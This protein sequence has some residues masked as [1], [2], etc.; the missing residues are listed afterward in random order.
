MQRDLLDE[1]PSDWL[2]ARSSYEHLR[3]GR[4]PQL[5]RREPGLSDYANSMGMVHSACPALAELQNPLAVAQVSS[6]H[7][8][9]SGVRTPFA[10]TVITLVYD[11]FV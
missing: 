6:C 5:P 8:V 4:R 7:P 1:D 10:P 9:F 11:T 2:L 3:L